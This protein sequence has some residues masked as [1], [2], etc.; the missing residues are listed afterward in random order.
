MS[1]ME[2]RGSRPHFLRARVRF[3]LLVAWLGVMAGALFAGTGNAFRSPLGGPAKHGLQLVVDTRWVDANGYRPVRIKANRV[4]A[5]PTAAERNLQIVLRSNHR[6]GGCIYTT[7]GF[8]QIPAGAPSAATT[9]SVP[10]F[11]RWY[12]VVMYVYEDGKVLPELTLQLDYPAVGSDW[13]EARPAILA[14]DRDAPLPDDRQRWRQQRQRGDSPSQTPTRVL[15]DIR[16]LSQLVEPNMYWEEED[17]SA[18][19][20]VRDDADSLRFLE[21]L[22]RVDILPPESLPTR[23]IDYTCFDLLVVSLAD[24]KKLA[25]DQPDAWQAIRDWLRSGPTLCVYGAEF[26][27]ANLVE[28][29]SLVECVPADAETSSG[30]HKGGWQKPQTANADEFVFALRQES[31]YP[32]S[33]GPGKAK[34]PEVN[35]PLPDRPPF[36]YRNVGNGRLVAMRGEEPFCAGPYGFSW[37]LNEL[38]HQ[39]WMWYQRHGM[40]LH[41]DNDDYWNWAVPGIGRAPVGVFLISITAFVLVIGPLNY[42]VLRKCRRLYLL[43]VTVASAAGLISAALFGYALLGDGLGVR[44]RVRSF[45]SLD[46]RAAWSVSWSR[47]SYYAGLA[48]SEGLQFPADAAVYPLVRSPRA[49]HAGGRNR[50]QLVWSDGQ[51]LRAGFLASRSTAQFLVIQSGRSRVG[52]AIEESSGVDVNPRVVNRLG[53]AIDQ[54]LLKDEHERYFVAAGVEPGQLCSLVAVVPAK[55]TQRLQEALQ[56]NLPALPPD[57]NP[58]SVPTGFGDYF[59]YSYVDSDQSPPNWHSGLLERSIVAT[60]AGVETLPPRS[61]VALTR[62]APGVPLGYD[63]AQEQA[64]FHVVYGRW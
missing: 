34:K 20:V 41:R 18:G 49:S 28:L 59:Y 3:A 48:P 10:Q 64:S 29:E 31:M 16:V 63:R 12:D 51:K 33:D 57:Y 54:L 39:N 6:Y 14:I 24:A 60:L 25:A 47:Q 9:L 35:P 13:S 38:G 19:E 62:T 40:S 27:E 7:T 21:G 36:L 61:Y 32:D 22:S 15:P 4:P 44:V 8:L 26:G 1:G 17:P 53:A 55:A 37:L 30:K 56:A 43:P 23:W 52:L 50:P 46:Q 58:H 2:Q 5:R 45:T 11:D 42:L